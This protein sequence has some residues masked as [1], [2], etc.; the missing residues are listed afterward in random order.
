[1]NECIVCKSK[2]KNKKF[3]SRKCYDTKRPN[4]IKHHILNKKCEYCKNNFKSNRQSAKYCSEMCY[5]NSRDIT[6]LVVKCNNC[7]SNFKVKKSRFEKGQVKYCSLICRNTSKEWIDSNILKNYN[8]LHKVGLNKLEIKGS[9][10]LKD[11]NIN[12]VEQKLIN[13]KYVVDVFIPGSNIIIQWD[14]DYWHGH[15]KNLKNGIANKLQHTNMKKDIRINEELENLGYNVLRFWQDD[16]DN[17]TDW[18]KMTIKEN[19]GQ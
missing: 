19:M 6:N 8:Q 5:Q 10:I 17:N 4:M 14:G 16:V 18:V 11:L 9:E 1:M 13:E 12:F 3:C 7:Q 15:P 2:T